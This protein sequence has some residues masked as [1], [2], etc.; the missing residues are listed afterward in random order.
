MVKTC[1][2]SPLL[3]LNLKG[4]LRTFIRLFAFRTLLFLTSGMS[5]A[6]CYPFYFPSLLKIKFESRSYNRDFLLPL[7]FFGKKFCFGYVQLL[8]L[9]CSIHPTTRCILFSFILCQREFFSWLWLSAMAASRNFLVLMLITVANVLRE[10]L[11]LV[12]PR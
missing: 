8:N 11:V 1:F 10:S 12:L 7:F 3:L 6:W 4:T 5:S 2:V 9:N